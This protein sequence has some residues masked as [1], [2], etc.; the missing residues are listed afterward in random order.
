[1]LFLSSGLLSGECRYCRSESVDTLHRTLSILS[2]RHCRYCLLDIV[3]TLWRIVWAGC[4]RQLVSKYILLLFGSAFPG[5]GIG[6]VVVKLG[7]V[8]ITFG[9]VG[10]GVVGVLEFYRVISSFS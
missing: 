9:R 10:S 2:A 5:E 4:G 7:L 8:H 1:M 3:D 6:N